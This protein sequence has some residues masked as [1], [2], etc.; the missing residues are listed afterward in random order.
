MLFSPIL[1]HGRSGQDTHSYHNK[2]CLRS[3]PIYRKTIGKHTSR[4][5]AVRECADMKGQSVRE[6][7]RFAQARFAKARFAK[8]RFA[9]AR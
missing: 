4:D 8:A 7:A 2:L 1:C 3:P 9:Q 6:A 5:I